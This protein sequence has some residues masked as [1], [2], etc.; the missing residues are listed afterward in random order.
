MGAA[1]RVA[2]AA[3]ARAAVKPPPAA[4]PRR[5]SPRAYEA[6]LLARGGQPRWPT[7]AYP[8]SPDD[9]DRTEQNRAGV[10]VGA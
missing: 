3:V 2:M 6:Q 4:S 8:P 10:P 7:C 9:D 1:A 5:H